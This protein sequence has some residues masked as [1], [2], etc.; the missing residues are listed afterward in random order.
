MSRNYRLYRLD[1]AGK[2]VGAEWFSAEDDDEAAVQARDGEVR[3]TM[4][5]WDRNRFVIRIDPT[6]ESAS[7]A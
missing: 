1:G 6:P 2:I 4:E 3:S 7:E 5:I